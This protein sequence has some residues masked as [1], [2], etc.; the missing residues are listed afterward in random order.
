MRK[1][2]ARH[3]GHASNIDVENDYDQICKLYEAAFYGREEEKK[4][5]MQ[6]W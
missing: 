1:K 6:Q 2:L 3:Q 4:E 5:A